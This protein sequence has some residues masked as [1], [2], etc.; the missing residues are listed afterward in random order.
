ML[1]NLNDSIG[2]TPQSPFRS[3]GARE[4]L[5]AIMDATPIAPASRFYF[6][7]EEP[8]YILPIESENDRKLKKS[9]AGD[10]VV[11]LL[12]VY[13]STTGKIVRIKNVELPP[14]INARNQLLMEESELLFPEPTSP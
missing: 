10:V 4:R 11:G 7:M 9:Y 1:I 3:E 12:R 13:F 6:F 14:S 2:Y 8:A 5:Y